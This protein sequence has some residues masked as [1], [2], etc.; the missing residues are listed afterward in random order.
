ANSCHTESTNPRPMEV[1][2]VGRRSHSTHWRHTQ[3]KIRQPGCRVGVA[4]DYRRP[5]KWR[6]HAA[7]D[8]AGRIR[9]STGTDF[10]GWFVKQWDGNQMSQDKCVWEPCEIGLE[11]VLLSLKESR[12]EDLHDHQRPMA[13]PGRNSTDRGCRPAVQRPPHLPRNPPAAS[14][15]TRRCP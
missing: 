11:L 4:S 15:R 5:T 12:D 10:G 1:R 7:P 2:M 8:C 9:L 14:S 13:D 6:V 3:P